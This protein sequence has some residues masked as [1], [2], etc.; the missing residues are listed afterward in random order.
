MIHAKG[1]QIDDN[2]LGNH[3]DDSNNGLNIDPST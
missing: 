3:D 1:M 2:D